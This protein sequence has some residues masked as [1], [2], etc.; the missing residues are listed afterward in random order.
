M[1]YTRYRPQKFNEISKPNDVATA[2][3]NQVK[4]GKTVHAYLFVGPR[5]TGKT[6]TARVLA[7]AL[8]CEHVSKDGDPCDECP[9][10]IGI[11]NGSFLDL[12]EIDA[13]S[14]RGIDDIR[15]LREKIKLAPSAGKS[16]VY[17]I[18]EVHM[19]TPEAFNA[20]LKTLEEPP[21]NVIFILC[22]TELHKVPETIKSRC[23]VFKFKRATFKQLTE[24][25]LFITKQENVSVSEKDLRQIAS[26]AQG[27]FRDAENLLQQVVEGE[28][29]VSSL[30]SLG[31]KDSYADFTEML[32]NKETKEALHYIKK[33][34]EDGIDLYVW[35]GELLRYLRELLF[36]QV[37]AYEDLVDVSDEMLE[38]MKEQAKL[39]NTL[40]TAYVI[41]TLIE[42]QNDIKSSFIIQ[43]P[44]EVAIVNLCIIKGNPAQVA[45]VQKNTPPS[46]SEPQIKTQV[47]VSG[48]KEKS[49]KEKA[50][51][52]VQ[53]VTNIVNI[54]IVHNS[55]S[56]VVNAVGNVNNSVS[57]LLKASKIV[58]IVDGVLVLEVPF[59]FHKERLESSKN[60]KIVEETLHNILE[61]NLV[62]SCTVKRREI[63]KAKPSETGK[64]TDYN[65]MSPSTVVPEELSEDIID[66]FD[67]GLPFD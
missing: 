24:K 27:G 8:N 52:K 57:A 36:V 25:L 11:K 63:K 65:V 59:D 6:T 43:L 2:L 23:Q 15:E 29:D 4:S 60:R 14:N 40:D 12:I 67:G 47:V 51:K 45:E 35:T 7:K 50:K 53:S 26:A 39:L 16:K 49:A 56:T 28:L 58:D 30:V 64:L 37:E 5:G 19:L 54:E 41:N 38:R 3:S 31:S 61:S 10:C 20:L 34:F 66:V 62:I 22:T 48:E 46:S 21:K 17:I 18:D 1:Y 9:V 13:A 55:W 44:L 33:L 42:A 32:I